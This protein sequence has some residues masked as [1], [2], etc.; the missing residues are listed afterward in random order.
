LSLIQ[1][2]Y[3]GIRQTSHVSRVQKVAAILWLEFMV[4]VRLFP[5]KNDLY[6]YTCTFRS[7]ACMQ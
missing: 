3:N 1:C 6:F 7:T 5:T 2:I 4:Y